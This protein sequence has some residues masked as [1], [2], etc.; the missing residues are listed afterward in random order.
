MNRYPFITAIAMMLFSMP[1]W[2]DDCDQLCWQ[3]RLYVLQKQQIVK[4]RNQVNTV[5]KENER[6]RKE[7]ELLKKANEATDKAATR[8]NLLN[9]I[10]ER[11]AK[12][13]LNH[14][15]FE[16]KSLCSVVNSHFAYGSSVPDE[17]LGL[18]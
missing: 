16:E 3:K 18:K 9:A 4:Q 17:M 1:I 8:K 13:D 5:M 14:A 2:A 15:T 10:H 7:N 6:L 11:C 12:E